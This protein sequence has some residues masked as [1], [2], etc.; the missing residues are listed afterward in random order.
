MRKR[1]HPHLLLWYVS[2]TLEREEA[3]QIEEH[4]RGCPDCR[5]EARALASTVRTLVKMSRVDHLPAEE[6]AAF[7]AGDPTVAAARR[8]AIELHVHACHDCREDLAT[9]QSAR[10]VRASL[11]EGNPGGGPRRRSREGLGRAPLTWAIT[12]GAVIAL[13]FVIPAA[14]RL[15]RRAPA[16]A[17]TQPAIS[18]ELEQARDGGGVNV[19]EG[20][21]PWA[22]RLH[23]PAEA[24]EGRYTVRIQDALG[25]EIEGLDAPAHRD[26]DGSLTVYLRSLPGPGGYRVILEAAASVE[27]AYTFPIV[28]PAVDTRRDTVTWP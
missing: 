3:A 28:L 19:L 1:E 4:L 9:L 7:D 21:G 23:L 27:D 13:S 10:R 5:W 17:L 2:G 12:G 22:L 16:A 11:A 14:P 25:S 20:R 8:A 6:L 18:V 24:A 26:S 15:W